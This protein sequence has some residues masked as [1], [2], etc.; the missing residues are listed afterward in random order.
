[1]SIVARFYKDK[2]FLGNNFDVHTNRLEYPDLR[3][4]SVENTF[5]SIKPWM[6]FYTVTVYDGYNFT[7]NSYTFRYPTE[8]ANLSDYG[9]NDDIK[10]LKATYIGNLMG[11]VTLYR[12]SNAKGKSQYF[13][14]GS[15][16]NL[17]NQPIGGDTVSSIHLYPKT[18][19]EIFRYSDYR[20][21]I[22]VFTN[23]TIADVQLI[24]V[25]NN[26]KASSIIVTAIL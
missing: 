25:A 23:N 9:L 1:M 18:T 13:T 8:V 24:K 14:P 4:Y 17:K 10:S 26:D 12:D 20:N 19:I 22:E 11:A 7:G 3:S 21:R 2:N 16:S 15:Y 5:S 6:L